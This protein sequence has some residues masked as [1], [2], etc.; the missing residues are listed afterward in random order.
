ML[1]KLRSSFKCSWRHQTDLRCDVSD[2]LESVLELCCRVA[3]IR[4]LGCCSP[5]H[6]SKKA[7]RKCIASVLCSALLW[8]NG[9]QAAGRTGGN[10]PI[11]FHD[12]LNLAFTC[13]SAFILCTH[14]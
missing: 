4:L 14:T 3:D 9:A 6:G 13:Q 8:G 7:V 5:W 12:Y 1:A 11:S 2:A 10:R